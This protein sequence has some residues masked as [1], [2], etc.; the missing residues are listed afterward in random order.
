MIISTAVEQAL[1]KIKYLCHQHHTNK[2][3][4]PGKMYIPETIY[5]MV[6]Y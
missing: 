1:D 2:L 6:K 5:P 3:P 4:Q